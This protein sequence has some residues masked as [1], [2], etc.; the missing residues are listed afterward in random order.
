MEIRVGDHFIPLKTGN[1]YGPKKWRVEMRGTVRT[2]IEIEM[3][4]LDLLQSDLA[5]ID[6]SVSSVRSPPITE[7]DAE[8][9]P[10]CRAYVGGFA[11]FPSVPVHPVGSPEAAKLEAEWQEKALRMHDQQRPMPT[12][13]DKPSDDST[14][15]LY[16]KELRRGD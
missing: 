14:T 11:I 16:F 4:A 3:T 5:W 6:P 13:A 2:F 1:Q 7:Q 15:R 10:I 9:F 8:E 12:L